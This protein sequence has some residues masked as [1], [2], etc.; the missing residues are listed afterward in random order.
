[1][2]LEGTERDKNN[3]ILVNKHEKLREVRYST[4]QIANKRF[5]SFYFRTEKHFTKYYFRKYTRFTKRTRKENF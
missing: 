4:H 1:M 5:T 3:R 2:K